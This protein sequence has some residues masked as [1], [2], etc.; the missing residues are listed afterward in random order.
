MS[1][2]DDSGAEDT[3]RPEEPIDSVGG[4]GQA[5]HRRR[6]LEKGVMGFFVA[7]VGAKL[8]RAQQGNLPCGEYNQFHLLVHDYACGTGGKDDSDACCAQP[9][10]EGGTF[11]D[12]HHGDLDC[13]DGQGR[14]DA[15]CGVPATET[16]WHGDGACHSQT[17]DVSC[18]L[19]YSST[20]ILEDHDCVSPSSSDLDCLEPAIGGGHW[21]DGGLGKI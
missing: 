21:A 1:K 19:T 20:E 6:L 7:F 4:A 18:G 16:G 5:I 12:P 14:R 3:P 17:F 13:G 11:G 10:E 9:Y 2:E 15:D 8:L